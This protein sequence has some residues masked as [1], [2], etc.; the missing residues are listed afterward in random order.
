MIEA[1]IADMELSFREG[2][3]TEQTTFFFSVDGAPITV[4]VDA[5]CYSVL[6]G[7][8]AGKPDCACQTGAGMFGR[9]WNE[10]YRPGIMD[11]LGGAIRC[12]AP[13]LLPRFLKAFGK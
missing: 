4:C 11:F 9:I 8:P 13:L 5:A 2:V 3:F 1:I 7:E 12:D 10:G 6:R